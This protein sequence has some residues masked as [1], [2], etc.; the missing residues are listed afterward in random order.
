MHRLYPGRT[1][2]ESISYAGS[3]GR[4][5]LLM[6]LLFCVRV[7]LL[8]GNYWLSES[9]SG[10]EYVY[11]L[12]WHI[13]LVWWY[14]VVALCILHRVRGE[15]T[16]LFACMRSGLLRLC[17]AWWL[18]VW[19]TLLS[20][21]HISLICR[22]YCV[23]E[24]V[25]LILLLLVSILI[26]VQLALN[27]FIVPEIADQR[28][29]VLHLYVRAFD[30]LRSHF[31]RMVQFFLLLFAFFFMAALVALCLVLFTR[32]L[33]ECV[34]FCAWMPRVG[35]SII[36]ASA[37]TLTETVLVVAQ[38]LFYLRRHERVV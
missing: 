34:V 26:I 28:Y 8:L 38:V 7:V 12:L 17:H 15:H 11:E 14:L 32:T 30:L 10:T 19:M 18:V 2:L 4:L 20:W 9:Y 31:V 5:W 16:G 23:T 25:D 29:D 24:G 6:L 1:M 22:Y 35:E 13:F 37:T 33:T 36:V 3:S 27:F 21:A